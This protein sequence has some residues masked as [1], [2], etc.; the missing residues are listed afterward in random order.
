MRHIASEGDALNL[1]SFRGAAEMG[2][3]AWMGVNAE[4]EV[5]HDF[6]AGG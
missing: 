4:N 1:C 6:F 2:G 5:R 3:T